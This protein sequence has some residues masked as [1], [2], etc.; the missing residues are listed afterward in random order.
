[1]MPLPSRPCCRLYLEIVYP[2]LC[3][4]TSRPILVQYT[5]GLQTQSIFI[6]VQVQF[7]VQPILAILSSSL[8]SEI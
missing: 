5:S 7:R 3:Y 6:R 4:P 2:T 8:S 1:M